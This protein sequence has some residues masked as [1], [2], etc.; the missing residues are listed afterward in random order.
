MARIT[1]SIASR[2]STGWTLRSTVTPGASSAAAI[3]FRP[4]FLVA[5]ETRTVPDSG[6]PARTTKASIACQLATLVVRRSPLNERGDRFLH[7]VGAQAH[8]LPLG[9][10]PQAVARRETPGGV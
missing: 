8:G 10:D 2:S 3:C 1:S 6:P 7:V 4:A 9:L 5:P